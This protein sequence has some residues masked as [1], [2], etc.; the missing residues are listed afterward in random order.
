MNPKIIVIDGK[1]Y[2]SVNEMPEQV[3]RKYEQAISMLNDEDRSRIP[4][5]FENNNILGDKNRNNIPDA[6]ENITSAQTFLSSM[7]VVVDGKEINSVDDLPP[8]ARARYDKAMSGLD[9]NRNGVPDFMEGMIGTP[10][11]TTPVSTSF[12]TE[13]SRHSLLTPMVVS[14][15]IAPDTSN[16]WMLALLGALVMF[17]CAA[18]GVG[19]WYFFIR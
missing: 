6:F 16:G 12:D 8:D 19:I 13:P 10:Q 15:N 7:K 11:Q 9:A 2:N 14:P 3:R 4:D 18:A 17:V 5:A 1:T